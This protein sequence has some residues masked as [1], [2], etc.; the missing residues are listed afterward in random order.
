MS[1]PTA[2]DYAKHLIRLLPE[3]VPLPEVAYGEDGTISLDWSIGGAAMT[4]EVNAQGVCI[5]AWRNTISKG[6]YCYQLRMTDPAL[7][8]ELMNLFGKFPWRPFEEDGLCCEH[9]VP[10]S[11][12]CNIC[13]PSPRKRWWQQATDA[14]GN[15]L[16]GRP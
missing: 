7:P 2:G 5:Y 14:I 16:G 4:L 13:N 12:R 8:E 9:A 11:A 3:E 6:S 1:D 15:A 10:L